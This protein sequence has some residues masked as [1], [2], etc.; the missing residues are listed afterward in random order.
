MN[1]KKQDVS[2][3][4]QQPLGKPNIS[5][6]MALLE[7]NVV[8]VWNAQVQNQRA[9][10]AAFDAVDVKFAVMYRAMSDMVRG[11]VYLDEE[12]NIDFDKYATEYYVTMAFAEAVGQL[13]AKGAPQE[14]VGP[15]LIQRAD[16]VEP[17]IFGGP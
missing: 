2:A 10:Q 13:K 3:P 1:V 11:G 5:T 4:A 7:K 9:Y 6:A 14:E 8:Q 17:V 16:S 15:G 12:K